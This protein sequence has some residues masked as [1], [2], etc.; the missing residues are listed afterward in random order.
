MIE[1]IEAIGRRTPVQTAPDVFATDGN[2]S[3]TKQTAAAKPSLTITQGQ[4]NRAA[5][6][7][8]K[9]EPA[10]VRLDER[11]R[12]DDATLVTAEYLQKENGVHS[13]V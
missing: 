3:K 13:I 12:H 7:V 4:H 5:S 6:G 8:E 9:A 2:R 1:S 10:E 11:L